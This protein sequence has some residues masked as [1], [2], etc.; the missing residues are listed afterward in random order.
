MITEKIT[1]KNRL[2][3]PPMASSKATEDGLVSVETLKFYDNITRSK[4]I[5][6]VIVE[7]SYI[8][9]EGKA[10]PKQT[11]IATDET[12]E[13]MKKL[14]EVLHKNETKAILQINHAGSAITMKS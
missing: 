8:S 4:N 2:V 12:I 10:S 1:L 9:I 13:P 3:Y 11:S 7:H 14:V 5:G 6:L